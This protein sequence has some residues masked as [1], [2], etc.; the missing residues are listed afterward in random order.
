MAANLSE[1]SRMSKSAWIS[2]TGR[3]LR[4]KTEAQV[5]YAYL[6][7]NTHANMFGIYY[8]P[9]T[10]ISH[11]LGQTIKFIDKGLKDLA[12]VGFAYY[13]NETEHT[14]VIEMAHWQVGEMHGNDKRITT[15]NKH[16]ASM[17]NNPFL[18]MFYDRYVDELSLT[19]TRRVHDCDIDTCPCRF[20]QNRKDSIRSSVVVTDTVSVSSF[21]SKI[22]ETTDSSVPM[23]RRFSDN[24]QN[25]VD[26]WNDLAPLC[27]NRVHTMTAKMSGLIRK[28]LKECP[29]R[30][31]WIEVIEGIAMSTFLRDKKWVD[32]Y[33]VVKVSEGAEIE[34]YAK[35]LNG[36]Y[37]DKDEGGLSELT[38]RN[39]EAATRALENRGFSSSD[40][41]AI[42]GG[43][44]DGYSVGEDGSCAVNQAGGVLWTDAE[45][46]EDR[47]LPGG[48]S[49]VYGGSSNNGDYLGPEEHE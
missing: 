20:D 37:R 46:G 40:Q 29:E 44:Q 19:V 49:G 3:A 36:N 15:A 35:I 26:L 48:S 41:Q 13:D 33:W 32:L 25:L 16:Y 30:S 18:G 11:E 27:L 1:Y 4:G 21:S 24:P 2:S 28:A 23:K 34:N 9:K 7:Y 38:R 31:T 6:V 47:D 17:I 10:L 45:Y 5:L 14:Y 12:D 39:M 22:E 8:L 43:I 42:I